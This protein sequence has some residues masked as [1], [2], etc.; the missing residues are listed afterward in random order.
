MSDSAPERLAAAVADRYRLEREL[1]QGGMATVYL[2]EDLK[3]H[4]KVALK[5]LRPELAATLGAERFLREVTIAANLQHPNILPV[6]DS[7]EAEGF[8]FYVMP[9]VEGH[10]LRERLA[11]EGELPVPEAARILRD[12]A[13]ALSAAHEKGVVHRDIKPENVLLTGRHALVA[14]FGVA[15]AVSEATGRQTLTTAGVALGTPTYM[16]PEQAAA[17]PHIDHRADLYAFGVMAYEM[18]TGQPPF[19]AP[20]PQA[21][22][23][24]HVT[25]APVEVTQRRAT[26]PP[27]L[28]Q[29]IMR[30]LAKKAADRPQTADELLPVLESFTTPSGGITPTD[31]RPVPA[32]IRGRRLAIPIAVAAVV[33]LAVA[34][35]ALWRSRAGAVPAADIR[36]PVLVLPFVERVTARELQ[37]VGQQMADRIEAGITEATLGTVLQWRTVAALGEGAVTPE[38]VRSVARSSGAATLV[39]GVVSQRGDSLEVQSQVLRAR[40]LKTLFSLAAEHGR[41][42]DIGRVLEAAKERALGA[43][44]FYLSPQFRHF[45]VTL[46]R[47]PR[48]VEALRAASRGSELYN[49]G[50]WQGSIRSFAE[51]QRQDTAF[52]GAVC[53][54]Q[55]A[56]WIMRRDR[57]A[58]SL[59]RWLEARRS[60]LTTNES[61]W[62]GVFASWRQ[63]PEEEY[64][65]TAD[66]YRWDMS[67]AATLQML[68][69]SYETN[70]VA[71]A[72]RL[73]RLRDTTVA[74]SRDY[75]SWYTNAAGA[76]HALGRYADELALA[77]DARARQPDRYAHAQAQSRALIGL[78]RLDDLEQLLTASRSVP[79]Y[80]AAGQLMHDIGLEL[81]AHGRR[82]EARAMWQRAL[83]WH[84]AQPPE[85]PE[86]R[87]IRQNVAV[88]RYYL[89]QYAEALLLFGA[90]AAQFPANRFYRAGQAYIAARAGDTT[91]ALR[92]LAELRADTA[93]NDTY[94]ARILALL[95]RREEAVAALREHLNRGGRF[96]LGDWRTYPELDPLRDYPPFRALVALKD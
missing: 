12:V 75:Y 95:G 38:V 59:L 58:D 61:L 49:R 77:R 15:K 13:D 57:E 29:L 36:E 80:R 22:L 16:A 87:L 3:H 19:T 68:V 27:L 34:G 71:E 89:G 14:D 90:L 41:A 5:V 11:K 7:G 35:Y 78:G 83:D 60:M 72:V 4:R 2:A 23:S 21:L 93:A 76:M 32:V 91:A 64:R 70:H 51:A 52:L 86:E 1:G 96:V 69:A 62:V 53:Y 74:L 63:S 50:D 47:P 40:D 82:D 66:L 33:V 88:E 9:F 6:H 17:S 28:A 55:M 45:E 8:L 85:S 42:A 26:I 24:A 65:A 10:S 79:W 46:I 67:Q 39:T 30:C 43:V 20:T 73:Y 56:Y 81:W 92:I 44:G 18:L 94:P 25:E 37:G 84:M 48:G 54:M 31:T